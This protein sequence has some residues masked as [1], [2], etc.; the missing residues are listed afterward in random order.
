MRMN[1]STEKEISAKTKNIIT[2]V[3]TV[4]ILLSI[5][6]FMLITADICSGEPFSY[7]DSLQET[8][9]AVGDEKITLKEATYYILVSESNYNAAAQIYNQDNLDAFWNININYRFL[10]NMTKQAVIDACTRDNVYYQEAR[11]AGYSLDAKAQEEIE[12]QAVNELNK[13]TSGQRAYTEYEKSDM[14]QVLTKIYYAKEYVSELMEQGFSGKDLDTGGLKY[15]KIAE[16]YEIKV[17]NGIWKNITL[18]QVT[19]NND[20]Q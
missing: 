13:M 7:K 11:K 3:C 9:L 15:E 2:A 10:K 19:I 1:N 12:D 17:Y 14:V 18:G 20:Y 6:A 16:D 8:A 5:G 4:V